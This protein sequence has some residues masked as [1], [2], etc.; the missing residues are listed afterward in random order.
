MRRR[1]AGVERDLAVP[2]FNVV[3]DDGVRGVAEDKREEVGE[4]MQ[5]AT[6]LAEV[7]EL[8]DKGGVCEKCDCHSMAAPLVGAAPPLGEYAIAEGRTALEIVTHVS[9]KQADECV[10][11]LLPEGEL[12]SQGLAKP[13]LRMPLETQARNPNLLGGGDQSRA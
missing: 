3:A 9:G 10:R 12:R 1:P 7:A 5:R 11:K 6:A 8:L 2:S 4:T 13:I